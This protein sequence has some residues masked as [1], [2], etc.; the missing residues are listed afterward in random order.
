M[1]VDVTKTVRGP[2]HEGGALLHE[3]GRDRPKRRCA[4]GDGG[5][6][7]RG[8]VARLHRLQAL[9]DQRSRVQVRVRELGPIAL[10]R[11]PS[12]RRI[13][14][15]ISQWSLSLFFFLLVVFRGRTRAWKR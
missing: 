2:Y 3:V 4:R 14:Q 9:A 8:E 6:V 10:L 13:E 1:R 12:D 11:A 15:E 5:N 7:D